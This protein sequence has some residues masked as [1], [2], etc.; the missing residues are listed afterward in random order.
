[1]DTSTLGL[2]LVSSVST[3]T[4]REIIY[5]DASLLYFF[6]GIIIVVDI[7]LLFKRK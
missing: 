3:S 7:I 2:F 5:T 1:M 6:L 4:G